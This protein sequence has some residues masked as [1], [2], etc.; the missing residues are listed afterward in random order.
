VVCA[1]HRST[2]FAYADAMWAKYGAPLAER[3][4]FTDPRSSQAPTSNPFDWSDYGSSLS[5]NGLRVSTAIGL[6]VHF[7]VC[8]MS[9][10]AYAGTVARAMGGE[11]AAI[12]DDLASH[13]VPNAHLVP[14]GIVAVNRAQERGYSFAYTG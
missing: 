7:A 4:G 14:A 10:R 12:Y 9:T 6:G 11:A 13:L 8:G 5:N 1:R 3:A 2:P